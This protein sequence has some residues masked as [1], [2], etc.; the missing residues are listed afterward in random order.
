M[1]K[2]IELLSIQKRLKEAKKVMNDSIVE[3]KDTFQ[4][5][6]LL[7]ANAE[8]SI[9]NGEIK[10]ALNILKNIEK[11]SPIWVE[12]QKKLANM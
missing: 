4:E 11:D 8:L 6:R 7:I 10:Q 1:L 12:S 3:F 9:S 5:I 2:L